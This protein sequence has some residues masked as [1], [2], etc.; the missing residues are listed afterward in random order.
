MVPFLFQQRRG[1]KK[2]CTTGDESR[3]VDITMILVF[4]FY[5]SLS[6]S[7]PLSLSLSIFLRRVEKVRAHSERA[8]MFDFEG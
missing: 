4:L 6:L 2:D 8:K 3:K 5:L 7:L 1:S